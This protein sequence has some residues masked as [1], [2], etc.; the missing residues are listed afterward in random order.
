[1]IIGDKDK[2]EAY[3]LKV[4]KQDPDNSSALTI[5]AELYAAQGDTNNA[6]VSIDHAIENTN[7][8]AP[9]ILE[10]ARL[11]VKASK[12]DQALSVLESEITVLSENHDAWELLGDLYEHSGNLEASINAFANA[13]ELAPLHFHCHLRIAELCI[14]HDELDKAM[15][16]LDNAVKLQSDDDDSGK[17]QETLGNLFVARKQFDRA[18]KAYSNSI[19]LTPKNASLYFN[20]GLALKQLKDY[21]EAM[22]MF[23]KSVDIDPNNVSAHRQLAAVSALELI[24]GD[25]IA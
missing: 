10:K 25:S 2:S 14:Q 6:L 18:Y 22:L 12:H 15:L 1:M 16:Y 5:L 7:N 11:L 8:P 13:I 20:A 21:S 24:S 19:K 9:V 23:R 3:A 4:L 17:L